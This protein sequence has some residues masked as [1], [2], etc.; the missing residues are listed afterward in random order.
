MLFPMPEAPERPRRRALWG[1]AL[2]KQASF[3]ADQRARDRARHEAALARVAD[4]VDDLK[5]RLR[6]V[7]HAA[8]LADIGR[9]PVTKPQLRADD[10]HRPTRCA[11]G[12]TSHHQ[13]DDR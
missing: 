6:E 5:M 7:E 12:A 11:A 13:G 3:F 10:N 4:A 2:T 8:G 9:A 1:I